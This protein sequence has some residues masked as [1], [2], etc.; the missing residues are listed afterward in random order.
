[1]TLVLSHNLRKRAPHHRREVTMNVLALRRAA[2]ARELTL[3]SAS[4]MPGQE[5]Q[6]WLSSS[7]VFTLSAIW[8]ARATDEKPGPWCHCWVQSRDNC[9]EACLSICTNGSWEVVDI[10]CQIITL[11]NGT[12]CSPRISFFFSFFF[13]FFLNCPSF[14]FQL[15]YFE[16]SKW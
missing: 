10:Q 3:L 5:H 16:S 14:P 8:Q 12:S 11:M 6:P 15:F 2:V 9:L 13:L 7:A 4:T 1:M